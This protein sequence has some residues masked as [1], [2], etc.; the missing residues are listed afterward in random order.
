MENQKYL[1]T[2]Q[3]AD[4]ILRTPGSVRRLAT[5]GKIPFR[6]AGGRFMFPLAE[7]EQWIDSG[8]SK[9]IDE[10]NCQ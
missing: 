10:V 9:T 5:T 8:P 1:N 7:I 3:C 2:K 6:K 4:L